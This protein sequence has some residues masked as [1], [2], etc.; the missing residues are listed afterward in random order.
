MTLASMVR[1]GTMFPLMLEWMG[2]S[3]LEFEMIKK[4][5][6]A[7]GI[8]LWTSTCVWAQ[9]YELPKPQTA[10]NLTQDSTIVSW[11]IGVVFLIGCLV[12]AFKPTKRV[13][14]R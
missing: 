8:V 2:M 7:L 11:V 4:W 13:N 5:L 3:R 6:L 1:G 14:L 12:V 9:Q 10:D